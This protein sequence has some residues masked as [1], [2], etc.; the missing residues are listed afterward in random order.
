MQIKNSKHAEA[1][2]LVACLHSYRK[3]PWLQSYSLGYGFLNAI[4]GGIGKTSACGGG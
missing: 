2:R 3:V 1:A 4:V